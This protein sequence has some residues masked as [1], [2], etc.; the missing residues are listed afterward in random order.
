MSRILKRP[1][2]RTGGTPNEGIMHGIV[3][4]KGYSNGS[5]AEQYADEYYKMLSKYK[6]PAPKLPLGQVGL[7]LVSGEYAGDGLL[8][9]IARSAKGPYE[10]WTQADDATKNLDYQ[11][12]MSAAKMGISKDEAER[13]AMIQ[14]KAKAAGQNGYLKKETVGGA[15]DHFLEENK[16]SANA[17]ER[18]DKPNLSQKYQVGDAEFNSYVWRNLKTTTDPQG[19]EIERNYIEFVPFDVDDQEFEYD[20]MIPGMYYYDPRRRAFVQRVPDDPETPED[21][22]GYFQYDKKT[23]KKSKI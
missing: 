8:S 12:R 13:L 4:R 1:M 10:Q 23:F 5:Q 7:N 14:A 18:W 3:D 9:N 22:S 2:F 16:K 11:A 6:P 20:K 21:E 15:F 17:L 19:Q